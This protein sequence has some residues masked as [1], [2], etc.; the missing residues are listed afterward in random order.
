[1]SYCCCDALEHAGFEYAGFFAQLY[2]FCVDRVRKEL[3]CVDRV[4]RVSELREH[5]ALGWFDR[6]DRNQFEF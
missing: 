6:Q 1:M 5:L 3:L 4:V 2:M